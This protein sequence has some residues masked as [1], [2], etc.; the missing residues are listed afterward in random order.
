MAQYKSMNFLGLTR[1]TVLGGALVLLSG[2]ADRGQI[3]MLP[4][5]TPSSAAV[6][7]I[8]VAT[9]R[10]TA[11]P[12][13]FFSSGRS[14]S[15][16]FARFDISIPP[17]RP[18]GEVTY[19]SGD[20]DPNT[21]FLVTS[22]QT[23]SGERGFIGE[24]NAAAR[25]DPA[26]SGH[27][28]IFVH[29]YNTNFAEGLY[30][31]AQLGYDLRTPGVKVFFSWPSEAKLA[32]YLTDRESALFSRDDLASTISA[33]SRSN[34]R[35]FNVVGHSMGTFVL[36][37]TLR[38]MALSGNSAALRD[39][40][41]VIL[42][43]ADIEVDVFRRQAPPVLAAGIPI[44][45]IVSADDRALRFSARLRG[46]KDRLGSI[47]SIDE[48]GGLDVTVVDLSSIDSEDVTGH[49][50]SG[51]SP[52]IIAMVQALR[53]QGLAPLSSN[54]AP[55]LIGSSVGLLRIGTD[56]LIAPLAYQ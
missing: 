55:G 11:P 24:I 54:E 26:R 30:R 5:D 48:L 19:P 46:Q 47:S 45:V 50:K 49:L 51:T 37:E 12:P 16:S 23:L 9:S 36:M 32:A 8:I 22:Y 56:E 39:I 7:E 41:A 43:S 10:Q 29:G 13:E 14:Y 3:T 18:I 31:N 6:S 40:D 1:Q 44:Y 28:T 21:D 38:T 20:P 17:N 35:G 42:I 15:V 2:C 34:L 27:G 4:P 52:E 53:A 25:R 33:L